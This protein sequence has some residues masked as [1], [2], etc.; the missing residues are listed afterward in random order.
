MQVSE[1]DSAENRQWMRVFTAIALTHSEG[2]VV[3]GDDNAEPTP[4]HYHNWYEFWDTDLGFP[5]SEKRQLF[6]GIEGLFVRE[7]TNGYAFYNRSGAARIVSFEDEL[8]AVS[9]KNFA[10]NHEIQNLDGEIF[11]N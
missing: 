6:N 10:S 8:M 1:R 4:D 11:I 7:F 3:F 5:I 2:H 9:T